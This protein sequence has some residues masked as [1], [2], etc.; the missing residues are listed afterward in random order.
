MF[1]GKGINK[2]YPCYGIAKDWSINNKTVVFITEN[3]L[4]LLDVEN[5]NEKSILI[6]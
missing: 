2:N 3:K 6:D 5:E 1:D 4:V